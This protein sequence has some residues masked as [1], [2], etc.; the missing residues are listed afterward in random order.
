MAE[1][2]YSMQGTKIY[3]GS[4]PV[5]AKSEVEESD[6]QNVNWIEIK[7]LYQV[8]ALG[9]AQNIDEIELLSEDWVRKVKGIKNG[10]SMSNQFVPLFLDEG[11]KK[12]LEAIEECRPYPFKVDR[13]A[14]CTPVG[15]VTFRPASDHD[16]KWVGHGLE[17]GQHVIFDKNSGTL[18]VDIIEGTTYV[19]SSI[20]DVDHFKISS[21]G[22]G[23]ITFT[24]AGTPGSDGFFI[25][26]APPM[27]MTDLFYGL[28]TDGERSG[29]SASDLYTRTWTIAVD[30]R[31]L[32]V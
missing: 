7:G 29:G 24:S 31:V 12:Y 20:V 8:G 11:Q 28:A 18:P 32:T 19:V 22:G 25:A 30:G 9:A 27:G 17:E 10:G 4:N 16:V 26:D 23:A 3:I 21:I 1:Q 2:L 6:F 14:S 5:Q 15:N 13:G